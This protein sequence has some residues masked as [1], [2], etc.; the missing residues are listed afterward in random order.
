MTDKKEVIRY[1]RDAMLNLHDSPL[2]QKPPSMPSLLS[3]FGEDPDLPSSKNILNSSIITRTSND[4]S[5]VLGPTKT[6]FASSLYG[7]LKKTDEL[8][9]QSSSRHSRQLDD[10]RTTSI[11]E[12]R[13]PRGPSYMG[14]KGFSHRSSD[15]N[16]SKSDRKFMSS[17]PNHH[18]K[19]DRYS[20]NTN[21]T[22][23]R[24]NEIKGRHTH[25]MH[26]NRRNIQYQEY[27][28]Q[29]RLPEWM[30]YS[31][32]TETEVK[33]EKNQSQFAND[34]E[35]WKSNMKKKD[36]VETAVV[37]KTEKKVE[38]VFSTM[39]IAEPVPTTT[40]QELSGFF[41]E[42]L[43]VALNGTRDAQKS[44]SRFA[45][46]FAKREDSVP[47][48]VQPRTITLNDL[49]KSPTTNTEAPTPQH[50]NGQPEHVNQPTNLRV[51]SEDDILKSLGAKKSVMPEQGNTNDEA[52]GFN[53]V[54]QILSQP[55][56]TFMNNN[57]PSDTENKHNNSPSINNNQSMNHSNNQS[58]NHS[59][60][61]ST[62]HSN[63]QSMNHSTS[64]SMNTA[65]QPMNHTNSNI[66]NQSMNHTNNHINNNHLQHNNMNALDGSSSMTGSSVSIHGEEVK[67]PK[68]PNRF[69]N[70]LPTSVLRQM[71]ARS[72]ESRSPSLPSTKP[73]NYSHP[74][75]IKTQVPINF[76]SPN[77]MPPQYPY[78]YRQQY[79]NPPPIMDHPTFEQLI[80]FNNGDMAA[81]GMLPP[82]FNQQT[83]DPSFL[84]HGIP[85][86]PPIPPGA[87]RPMMP[88]PHHLPLHLQPQP[89]RFPLQ[90]EM[91]HPNVMPPHVMS[92]GLPPPMF[93]KNQGW[94]RHQ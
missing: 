86:M 36:G 87:P 91:M 34:L 90:R 60:S 8:P 37:M 53:K 47:E 55:K 27:D 65:N 85:H 39:T 1:S 79:P 68:M 56:P 48:N 5:I 69:G 23:D 14:D 4:K 15:N 62:N 11:K 43:N 7:G 10:S 40:Q 35:A 78:L 26:N 24:N 61:Q 17:P 42:N 50:Y 82:H 89:P 38:E 13:A 32:E 66:N 77:N 80:Q 18:N 46:F 64:Q 28:T 93:T 74:S 12:Y 83:M 49:F 2:V 3:W 30:D 20:N 63:S 33:D 9:K 70:N 94:E 52:M 75:P 58:M 41:E 21:N 44:G 81:R 54:L 6:N 19:R 16:S 73:M 71:S 45:K 31:P 57:A 59:N 88:P 84:P 67:T 72:S 22:N 51:F 29:E 25:N 92:N 76:S